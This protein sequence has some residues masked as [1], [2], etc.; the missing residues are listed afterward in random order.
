MAQSSTPRRERQP[1]HD[2]YEL[3]LLREPSAGQTIWFTWTL[4]NNFR[5]PTRTD[6]PVAYPAANL[7]VRMDQGIMRAFAHVGEWIF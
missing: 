2:A 5:P 4:D 6:S 1:E 7:V 3:F